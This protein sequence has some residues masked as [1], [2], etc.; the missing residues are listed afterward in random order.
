MTT[1]SPAAGKLDQR[2][3]I[4]SFT[5]SQGTDGA[6]TK[7]WITFATRWAMIEPTNGTER[8][9]SDQ[10]ASEVTHRITMHYTAGVTSEMRIVL[11]SR[12]FDILS[13]VNRDEAGA[14][15]EILAVEHF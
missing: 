13:V 14:M 1:Q 6:L 8:W 9:R 4:Q 7:S 3:T 10:V 2:V 5:E 11:G 12:T 15:I